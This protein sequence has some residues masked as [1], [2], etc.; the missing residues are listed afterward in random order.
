MVREGFKGPIYCASATQDLCKILLLD[1][2]SIQEE[3]A[4]HA[5]H[6]G[7]SKHTN[8]EPLYTILDAEQAIAQLHSVGWDKQWHLPGGLEASFLRAGHILGAA[9]IHLSYNGITTTFSGDLGRP[10]DPMLPTP[11]PL[12]DSD[13]LILESTY[14]DRLH[15]NVDPKTELDSLITRAKENASV[16]LIPSF[17]VGRSQ[18][19]LYQ[20]W[21]LKNSG[22]LHDIPIFVDSP[23]AS[24]V[25]QL[26]LKHPNDHL[27]GSEHC[28][29]IFSIAHY[30]QSTDESKA[31]SARRV[32]MILLSASGIITGGRILHHLKMFGGNPKN[33]IALAGYQAEGTRGAQLVAGADALKIF[34]EMV[35]IKAKVVTLPNESAHADANEI[36]D[37]LRPAPKPKKVFI[38]HGEPNASMTLRDRIRQDLGWNTEAP[39]MDSSAELEFG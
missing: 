21:S 39:T 36:M 9:M 20:L 7:Y 38:T 8:P 28:R 16:I 18:S 11:E 2:A 12:R 27:L 17:A 33:A 1:S 37:W 34:G 35:P 30:V 10:K 23:M 29:E 26:Y 6:H 5:R 32:P 19:I 3:E 25:T 22:R 4:K 31:L 15:D 14:G 24:D 13:Y